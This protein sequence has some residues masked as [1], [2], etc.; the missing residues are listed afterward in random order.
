MFKKVVGMFKNT[1]SDTV[2]DNLDSTDISTVVEGVV[3]DAIL[4]NIITKLEGNDKSLVDLCKEQ[5]VS[6]DDLTEEQI[7]KIRSKYKWCADSG[8][9][10]SVEKNEISDEVFKKILVAIEGEHKSLNAICN[11]LL[12][13][14]SDLS[15]TQ[16]ALIRDTFTR[17]AK[18]AEWKRI[19]V[20]KG[21]TSGC[22]ACYANAKWN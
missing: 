6:I 9:W 7:A 2:S 17:C 18:C 13:N 14:M 12:V 19:K 4:N 3:S 22:R 11:S 1:N 20:E 5:G 21:N 8:D 10:K 15:E 16:L